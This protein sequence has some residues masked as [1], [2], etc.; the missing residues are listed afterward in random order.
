MTDKKI[1]ND[2][3]DEEDDNEF[4]L[5]NLVCSGWM[6]GKTDQQEMSNASMALIEEAQYEVNKKK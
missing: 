6:K 2:W 5:T 1:M 4:E 3:K